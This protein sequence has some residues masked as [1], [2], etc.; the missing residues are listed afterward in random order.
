MAKRIDGSKMTVRFAAQDGI[1]Q[2]EETGRKFL[3]DVLEMSWDECLLTDESYLSDF[4]GSG[5]HGLSTDMAYEDFGNA[6][7]AW[8]S[9]RV[10]ALYGI[11]LASV[12]VPLIDVF[13]QLEA[14]Q[15]GA[16]VH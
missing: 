8:V 16:R 6:W 7:H 4:Y 14:R 1:D 9:E 13:R 3:A 15:R 11:E 10:T 12:H 2:F 5:P